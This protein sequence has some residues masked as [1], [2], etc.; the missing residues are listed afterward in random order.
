LHL[1]Y[2]CMNKH[3]L[4]K[5]HLTAFFIGS[6][7]FL[8]CVNDEAKVRNLNQKKTGV[9]EAKS[10]VLNYTIGGKT[11]AILHAPLMLN[12]QD[13]VPY[14]EFPS[15]LHADFYSDLEK[16]ESMLDANYGKYE[17]NKSTVYLRDSVRVI[18]SEKGDTLYC[19]ELYWDRNRIGNEF[20]TDK[21]VR[22]RTRTQWINGKGMESGQD[23]KNW[24]IIHSEG[25]ISIPASQFPD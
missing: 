4:F 10:I 8:S 9:E 21:P 7:F 3:L 13:I 22:I 25:F 15:T 14:V 18:N 1:K 6:I 20:Y 12:V 17:Q 19:N 2:N 23:F 11:K 16:P 24:H 5:N